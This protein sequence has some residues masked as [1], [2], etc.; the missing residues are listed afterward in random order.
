VSFNAFARDTVSAV[1]LEAMP[2]SG[3]TLPFGETPVAVRATDAA[4]NV[5]TCSFKVRVIDEV[6]PVVNCPAD[7]EV[8]ATSPL[9]TPVSFG[10]AAT[11]RGTPIAVSVEPPSGSRFALGSTAVRA[12]AIDGAGNEG[13][14][15]FRVVVKDTTL[16]LLTCPRDIRVTADAEQSAVVSFEAT[17][18]DL[19]TQSPELTYDVSPDSRFAV[20]E[21]RVHV[22]ASDLSG[23]ASACEFLVSV[24]P[25]P[26]PEAPAGCGCGAGGGAGLWPALGLAALG[27]R[28]R[29][30]RPRAA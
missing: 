8:E 25:P 12:L 4:G 26:V 21:T 11:D 13:R 28:L 19:G 6:L 9:G 29:H 24:E 22:G 14:C 30:R 7:F 18:V 3:T 2:P 10:V 16:P 20:G 5:A 1:K 15:S 27:R 23:N 17:A